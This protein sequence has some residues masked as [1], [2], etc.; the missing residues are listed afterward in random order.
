[1]KIYNIVYETFLGSY[2]VNLG[3]DPFSEKDVSHC[4]NV[5][6]ILNYFKAQ[7]LERK[8]EIRISSDFPDETKNELVSKL[9]SLYKNATI[10]ELDFKRKSHSR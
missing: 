1:M 3:L 8:A 10:K 4:E 9:N 2:R 7:S 6:G 5:E